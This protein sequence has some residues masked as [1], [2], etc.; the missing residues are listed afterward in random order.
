MSMRGRSTNVRPLVEMPAFVSTR[1]RGT[2]PASLP[3]LSTSAS[4][5]N[6]VPSSRVCTIAPGTRAKAQSASSWVMAT[7]TSRDPRPNRG[8]TTHGPGTPAVLP[9]LV[10]GTGIPARTMIWAKI[11]LSSQARTAS[12]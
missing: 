12:G 3:S 7:C 1:H 5:L 8:L 9:R 10:A 11:H 2:A 4:T 6:S